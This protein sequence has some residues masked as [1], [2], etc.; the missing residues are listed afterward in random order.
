MLRN[1]QLFEIHMGCHGLSLSLSTS[2][3]FNIDSAVDGQTKYMEILFLAPLFFSFL[4]IN[5]R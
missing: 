5:V 4:A 2:P 3:T 1:V